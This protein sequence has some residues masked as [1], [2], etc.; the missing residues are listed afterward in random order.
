TKVLSRNRHWLEW[1]VAGK[2]GGAL[3]H[4]AGGL[5]PRAG[6][7]DALEKG[8]MIGRGRCGPTVLTIV[9]QAVSLNAGYADQRNECF[10]HAGKIGYEP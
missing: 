7:T 6:F 3:V 1:V 10:R 9:A 2:H 8:V 5:R 4:P